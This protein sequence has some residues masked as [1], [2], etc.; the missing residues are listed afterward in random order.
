M[1]LRQP[2]ESQD[3]LLNELLGALA[4]CVTIDVYRYAHCNIPMSTWFKAD[5][6][7]ASVRF[8]PP[9]LCLICIACGW[10]MSVVFGPLPLGLNDTLRL[11]LGGLGMVVGAGIAIVS[12]GQFWLTEQDP[13]PWKH[14]PSMISN[15]IYAWTR[16]PMYL[17]MAIFQAGLGIA[18]AQVWIV[19]FVPVFMIAV[20]R[21]AIT[22]EESY[23]AEKFAEDYTKYN[24]QVRR[25]L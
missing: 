3:R 18:L 8:P 20:Q 21:M 23:L 14:T 7:A 10:L 13:H 22:P 24:K 25:W 1:H 12:L 11:L 19:L 4:T 2:A 15:G 6:D 5:R 17:A 9:L 16:N